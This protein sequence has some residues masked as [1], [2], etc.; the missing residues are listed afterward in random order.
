VEGYLV[1]SILRGD[2]W[3]VQFHAIHGN[4]GLREG[5]AISRNRDDPQQRQQLGLVRGMER[6]DIAALGGG[7]AVVLHH[8]ILPRMDGGLHAGPVEAVYVAPRNDAPE[9]RDR[10]EEGGANRCH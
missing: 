4:V 3:L 8:Y 7:T 6:R 2:I 9:L 1:T 5:D 10:R